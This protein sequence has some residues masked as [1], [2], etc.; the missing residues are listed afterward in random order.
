MSDASQKEQRKISKEELRKMS[1]GFKPGDIIA[2]RYRV[3]KL[4]GRGG[5]GLVYRVFDLKTNEQLALKTLLPKYAVHKQAMARFVREVKTVRRL[6]H[7]GIVKI[8][9]ARQYGPMLYYTMEYLKGMTLRNYIVKR[10]KL[11][12]GSTVRI[13]TLLCLALEHAHAVTIHRDISPENVMLLPDASIRLLDFGLAKLEEPNDPALTRVGASLGK[14]LYK[15]PEQQVNAAAVDLRADI[16][17]LG[18]MFFE[19]L[20]GRLPKRDETICELIPDLPDECDAFLEKAM[21]F[22]PDERFRTVGDFRRALTEIYQIHTGIEPEPAKPEPA[23]L[24][25]YVPPEVKL[26]STPYER[27]LGFRERI[28]AGIYRMLEIFRLR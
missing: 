13:L 11:G 5:M 27:D 24:E 18:V 3:E 6:N 26:V 21:A 19:M 7:R 12:L 10:N 25:E 4:L 16:Y 23:K 17:P 14:M 15:A 28:M 2:T 20:V 1:K 8:F 22:D 9:D